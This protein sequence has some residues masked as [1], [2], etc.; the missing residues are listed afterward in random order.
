MIIWGD[1]S[2]N[3]GRAG[4]GFWCCGLGWCSATSTDDNL[5]G[6]IGGDMIFGDG[7]GGR[8]RLV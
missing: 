2:G 4:A 1:E 7:S 5:V 8:A 3:G 6:G